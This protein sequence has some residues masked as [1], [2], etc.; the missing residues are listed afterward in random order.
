MSKLNGEQIKR[1][2]QA[3]GMTQGE[4]CRDLGITTSMLS[5]VERGERRLTPT[6]A[7][8]AYQRFIESREQLAS[9]IAEIS[10]LDA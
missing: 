9:V 7:S 2:R 6:V 8:K 3:L 5:A 1:F 4:L 10:E